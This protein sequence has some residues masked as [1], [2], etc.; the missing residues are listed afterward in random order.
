MDNQKTIELLII[1]KLRTHLENSHLE[2]PENLG[3]Y[4]PD[5]GRKKKWKNFQDTFD[6]KVPDLQFSR[7]THIAVVTYLIAYIYLIIRLVANYSDLLFH[8]SFSGVAIGFVILIGFIVPIG[9]IVEAGK[10]KLPAK[11]IEGLV[12]KIIEL[13]PT[14]LLS[15]DKGTSNKS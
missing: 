7:I 14:D 3:F 8:L 15:D 5:K 1:E 6:F 4:F 10:T 2:R 13:N 9:I 12:D 11:N